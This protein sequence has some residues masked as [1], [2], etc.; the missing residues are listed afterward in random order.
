M[1]QKFRSK[2]IDGTRNYLIEEIEQSELISKKQKTFCT[3]RNYTEYFL[4]LAST[5]FESNLNSAF[6]SLLLL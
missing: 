4:I 6:A 2:S 5:I 3:T 1:S